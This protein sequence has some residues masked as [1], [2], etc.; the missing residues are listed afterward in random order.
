MMSEKP[1]MYA[2]NFHAASGADPLSHVAPLQTLSIVVRLAPIA[3]I[4]GARR[5]KTELETALEALLGAYAHATGVQ[6]DA[7]EILANGVR[8]CTAALICMPIVKAG[9]RL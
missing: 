7:L 1:L 9:A 3:D 6:I 8:A 2:I 4:Q 5:A